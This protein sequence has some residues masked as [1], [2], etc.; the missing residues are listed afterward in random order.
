MPLQ[1]RACRSR[2]HYHRLMGHHRWQD[3]PVEVRDAVTDRVGQ[4]AEVTPA[5]TG[6]HGDIALTL[7][8]VDA[9]PVFLKGVGGGP[10][11]RMRWLRNEAASAELVP[12]LAPRVLFTADVG[13]WFLVGFDH[14]EG[15]PASLVPGSPD[16]AVVAAT[17]DRIAAA[18]APGLRPLGDRWKAGGWW[19][20]TAT[21]APDVVRGFD[22]DTF[23]GLADRAASAVEGDRLAHT[24]L[25]EHQFLIGPGG[26]RV[27]DW[28]RPAAGAPWVDGAFLVIRLV[29]AGHSPAGAER[30]ARSLGC[31]N[32][33]SGEDLTA[34]FA[35]AAGLWSYRAATE[36]FPGSLR[37]ARVAR[38][39]AWWRRTLSRSDH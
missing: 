27:I 5:T 21:A 1:A 31:W 9:D 36:P 32:D 16:L 3:V 14:V 11:V 19:H 10:S 15:R 2:D 17:V 23:D 28:G 4:V 6:R 18:P 24:D 39:C 38:E 34:F 26:V 33:V 13:S 12:G 8:R 37:L 35:Y 7:H 29:M 30:W 25:H 22:V 20:K